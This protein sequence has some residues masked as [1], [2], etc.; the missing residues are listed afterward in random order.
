MKTRS[1]VAA[2]VAALSFVA[3]SAA[4]PA[5]IAQ[6]KMMGKKPGAMKSGKMAM[7]KMVYACKGCK[8]YYSAADAKKMKM[9]DSMGHQLMRMSM[10]DAKKMGMKMVKMSDKMDSKMH[11]KMHGKTMGGGGRM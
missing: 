7:N 10:A 8:M 6:D 3:V 1:N 5:A 11:D 9:K 2:L 4:I